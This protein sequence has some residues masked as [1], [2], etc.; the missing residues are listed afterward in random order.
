MSTEASARIASG[1]ICLITSAHVSANPRL[2]KEADT[3]SAAGYDVH[4]VALDVAPRLR[5][6][7][8][9]I[10]ENAAWPIT[11]V[12][13]GSFFS[14]ALKTGLQRLGR[15]LLS[16]FPIKS[17]WVAVAAHHR[18]SGKLGKSAR[19]VGAELYIAHNL[20]ALPA[21]AWAA[22]KTSAKLAF[23][24]EDFHT[25]ELTAD[26]RHPGDQVARSMIE[27]QFL[28]QCAYLTASAPMIA[29]AYRNRYGV[30]MQPIL[31]VF[32]K[33]QG[34]EAPVPT[35]QTEPR[36]LYWFS[37]TIGPA[38][39]LEEIIACLGYLRE[40]VTLYL[41]GNVSGNF[42]ERL[43]RTAAQCG[44]PPLIHI[45]PS[46][47][48]DELPKLAANYQLG[49]AVEPGSSPNNCMALS[50]KIFTY[51]LAGLPVLLSRTPAQEK[52]AEELGE[53][54]LLIDLDSPR[55]A[56]ALIESFMGDP[57]LQQRAR[58]AAWQLARDRFNWDIEQ[59]KVLQQVRDVLS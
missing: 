19:Q 14:Y 37:Q 42:D 51:L 38:R 59:L 3:L 48:P 40:P 45:L 41:R 29:E 50:N 9:S 47:R 35:D 20:A 58:D 55:D 32:P 6:L 26:Q 24:A 10:R 53:A 31:N 39:G 2:V 43:K 30:L 7:D 8:S 23:D 22:R 16:Y 17:S 52:L 13:R 25:E 12:N 1:R 44:T 49:L 21:A 11:L 5:Q 54:A 36:S 57:A 4:V 33:G 28:P 34:P 46:A 18:L 15:L 56:A 27:K